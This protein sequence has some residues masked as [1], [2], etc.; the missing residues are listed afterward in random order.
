MN[1][2]AACTDSNTM[3]MELKH[4]RRFLPAPL[5]DA[6]QKLW[7]GESAKAKEDITE[8]MLHR[9]QF[10]PIRESLAQRLIFQILNFGDSVATELSIALMNLVNLA[11]GSQSDEMDEWLSAV[12]GVKLV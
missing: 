11:S 8:F 3:E 7:R 5:S 6:V 12:T 4:F 1:T 2:Q 9:E 10:D